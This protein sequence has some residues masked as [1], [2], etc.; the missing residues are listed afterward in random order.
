MA[1]TMIELQQFSRVPPSIFYFPVSSTRLLPFPSYPYCT[2]TVLHNDQIAK[3]CSAGFSLSSS[4]SSSSP[5]SSLS[6]YYRVGSSS[7]SPPLCSLPCRAIVCTAAAAAAAV[8][9]HAHL[10][11]RE[12]TRGPS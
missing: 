10:E 1:E 3:R 8:D 4:S 5:S 9:F 2:L 12:T 7:S 11:E 6:N